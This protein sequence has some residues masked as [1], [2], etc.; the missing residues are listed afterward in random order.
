MIAVAAT[1][2]VAVIVLAGVLCAV[3]VGHGRERREWSF[4][5]RALVDRAIARHA[6]ETIALDRAANRVEK[7]R[8]PQVLVEGLT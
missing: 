4:E 6:G 3:T 1:L 8:E 2:A 5:R 7:E